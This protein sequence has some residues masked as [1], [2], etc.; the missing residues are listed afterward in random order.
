M[1]SWEDKKAEGTIPFSSLLNRDYGWGAYMYLTCFALGYGW[2][3]TNQAG[4]C[5]GRFRHTWSWCGFGSFDRSDSYFS[6]RD[7]SKQASKQAIKLVFDTC[8]LTRIC[9]LD[10]SLLLPSQAN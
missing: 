2:E 8:N 5:A 4:W 1:E 10:Y 9:F 6:A 3:Y 7:K